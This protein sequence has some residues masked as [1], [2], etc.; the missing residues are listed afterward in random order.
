MKIIFICGS[1]E[2]GRDGVGDYTRRLS[3]EL[4]RQGHDAALVA[5]NDKHVN[6]IEK[7]GQESDG[8]TVSVLRLPVALSNKERYAEAKKHIAGFNPEWLSLQFVPYS[9]QRKGLPFGLGKRLDKIGKGRKW[10][11]MFHELWIVRYRDAKF[12]N[13]VVSYVQRILIKKMLHDIKP[14]LIHTHIPLYKANLKSI[15]FTAIPLPLFS[16]V[17]NNVNEVISE[18][19]KQK[20]NIFRLGV[21]SRITMQPSIVN[22][23]MDLKN[24]LQVK[25][26]ELEIL[27]IGGVEKQVYRIKNEMESLFPDISKSVYTGFLDEKKV[28]ENIS[29]CDLGI[30][31]VPQHVLGK[32]GSALAFLTHHIPLAVPEISV[33]Y[34]DWGIGCFSDLQSIILIAPETERLGDIKKEMKDKTKTFTL[35]FVAHEFVSDM[36]L[37]SN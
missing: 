13:D 7:T 33:D 37:K 12:T 25:G 5:L 3:G 14:L 23:I 32:S 15:G 16:N 1:L 34:K 36:S 10:H 18:S 9:F 30:T 17:N 28:S 27:L 24:Q 31:S 19:Q 26:I 6:Q 20:T 11:V 22:F 35:N 2:P 4:I 29:V 8:T 21:F